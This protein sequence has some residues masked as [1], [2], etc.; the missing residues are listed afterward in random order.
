MSLLPLLENT[1]LNK[2]NKGFKMN[3][4]GE[5]IAKNL[6]DDFVEDIR[7]ETMNKLDVLWARYQTEHETSA[8]DEEQFYSTAWQIVIETL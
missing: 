4:L 3:T 5:Y 6:N 2:V 7:V 8:S 1:Q